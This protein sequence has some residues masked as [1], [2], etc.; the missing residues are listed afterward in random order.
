[1]TKYYK[2]FNHTK[3]IT[4]DVEVKYSEVVYLRWDWATKETCHSLIIF[5]WSQPPIWIIA[6]IATYIFNH[7]GPF[8][9]K[10]IV[11]YCDKRVHLTKW[12]GPFLRKLY[13]S[14]ITHVPLVIVSLL[15]QAYYNLINYNL[16]MLSRYPNLLPWLP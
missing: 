7:H 8:R 15:P 9:N 3:E 2:N 5:F 4:L 14:L 13:I 16:C 12:K 11:I 10:H 6:S 1:M